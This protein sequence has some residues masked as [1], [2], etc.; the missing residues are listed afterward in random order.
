VSKKAVG[1]STNSMGW[2]NHK[3]FF[4]GKEVLINHLG[5]I[6]Y[7]RRFMLKDTQQ[8]YRFILPAPPR[9]AKNQTKRK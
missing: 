4:W 3:Y 9:Q 2:N 6:V 1:L 7:K 8:F 5:Q